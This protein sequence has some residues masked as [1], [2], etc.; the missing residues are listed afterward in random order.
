MSTIDDAEKGMISTNPP[1]SYELYQS[2]SSTFKYI[3]TQTNDTLGTIRSTKEDPAMADDN[4][5]KLPASASPRAENMPRRAENEPSQAEIERPRAEGRVEENERIIAKK[6]ICIMAEMRR[7]MA[8]NERRAAENTDLLRQT[9]FVRFLRKA[10]G[11]IHLILFLTSIGVL[12]LTA[13]FVMACIGKGF[14]CESAPKIVEVLN[15][16]TGTFMGLLCLGVSKT[17]RL[18]VYFSPS[19]GNDRVLSTFAY[20]FAAC[21]GPILASFIKWTPLVCDAE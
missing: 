3:A 13:L 2:N 12:W 6:N 21:L 18:L 11:R 7:R 10:P 1:P 9:P 4:V 19:R 15:N 20:I 8:D 16:F 14:L 5:T 17:I